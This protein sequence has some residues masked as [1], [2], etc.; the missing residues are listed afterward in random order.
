M[1]EGTGC[2][3]KGRCVIEEKVSERYFVASI[4]SFKCCHPF[5]IEKRLVVLDLVYCIIVL[6]LK[7]VEHWV[8]KWIIKHLVAVKYSTWHFI[9]WCVRLYAC[10]TS[11]LWCICQPP[12]GNSH[13]ITHS[14]FVYELKCYLINIAHML[15]S[16]KHCLLHIAYILTESVISIVRLLPSSLVLV[17]RNELTFSLIIFYFYILFYHVLGSSPT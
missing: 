17:S 13:R 7:L 10:N 6:F 16:K 11:E 5:R 2:V 12:L 9:T 3:A 15:Y 14:L 8:Y 1:V 4:E